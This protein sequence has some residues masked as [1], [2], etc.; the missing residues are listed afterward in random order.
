MPS[1]LVTNRLRAARQVEASAAQHAETIAAGLAE[2]LGGELAAGET[3]PDLAL[4]IRLLGRHLARR[5]QEMSASDRADTDERADANAPRLTRDQAVAALYDKIVEVRRTVEAL[6]GPEKSV[7]IFGFK[8]A[9]PQRA[10]ALSAHGKQMIDRLRKPLRPLPPPNLPGLAA[11]PAR[12]AA[13]IEHHQQ[14]LEQA[15]GELVRKKRH[16]ETSLSHKHEALQ[17]FDEA[18][19]QVG[20]SLEGLFALAGQKALSDRVRP[21]HDWAYRRAKKRRQREKK[22]SAADPAPMARE[23]QD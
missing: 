20:R 16:A 5:G 3:L 4:V 23:G 9:T 11:D 21:A 17:S 2:K 7:T 15:L 8:G 10:A 12:W 14:A 18:Y 19:V 22:E 1:K 6:Y 13:E